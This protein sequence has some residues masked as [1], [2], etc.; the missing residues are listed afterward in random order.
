MGYFNVSI[1]VINNDS[2]LK[3]VRQFFQDVNLICYDNFDQSGVVC[4]YRY[5]GTGMTSYIDHFFLLNNS[6]DAIVRLNNLNVG[7]NLSD[8]NPILMFLMLIM[9]L[10]N[11][12]SNASDIRLCDC[13]VN[14]QC[15]VVLNEYPDYS[16][17][18][19]D[20]NG[21]ALNTYFA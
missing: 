7:Y 10:L 4:N 8:H 6:I 5:A 11:D 21:F 9:I 18:T 14:F 16:V 3:A 15:V 13:R 2:R 12:S 19:S 1:N 17:V 20:S